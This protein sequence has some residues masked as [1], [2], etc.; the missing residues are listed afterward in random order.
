MCDE[1]AS[2]SKKEANLNEEEEIIED[3]PVSLG[4]L[5][6][7]ITRMP[8]ELAM[9]LLCQFYGW[10]AFFSLEIFFTDFVG[11]VNNHEKTRLFKFPF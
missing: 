10:L 3:K 9:L 1:E 2:E 4:M 5:L 6:K 11:Q 8:K 7:S